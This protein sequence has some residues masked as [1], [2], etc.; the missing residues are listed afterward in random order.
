MS[1]TFKK[2]LLGLVILSFGVKIFAMNTVPVLSL[3][4]KNETKYPLNE[5]QYKKLLAYSALLRDIIGDF[6]DPL[7]QKNM[8]ISLQLAKQELLDIEWLLWQFP[9]NPKSDASKEDYI[10]EITRALNN[11]FGSTNTFPK[12]FFVN[13]LNAG[14]YL[15]LDTKLMGVLIEEFVQKYLAFTKI[16][17]FAQNEDQ[18]LQNILNSLQREIPEQNLLAQIK[19]S[20]K[21]NVPRN[22]VDLITADN[23]DLI[24]DR[25]YIRGIFKK[26]VDQTIA[27]SD[28]S[29][30]PKV[31]MPLK[32]NELKAIIQ[33]WDTFADLEEA[34]QK[35]KK[36]GLPD[37]SV[38]DESNLAQLF[39]QSIQEYGIDL[40]TLLNLSKIS[41][42]N[43]LP[44]QITK[45]IVCAW[46]EKAKK[47]IT[48]GIL[49]RLGGVSSLSWQEI[50]S[51]LGK[52]GIK[53]PNLVKLF[54]ACFHSVGLTQP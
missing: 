30:Y 18:F 47:E 7:K 14:N 21:Q 26:E 46:T 17:Q 49:A 25:K 5:W 43:K 15:Q 44:E 20:F 28:T 22:I 6:G 53:D 37:P 23:K 48:P 50:E 38:K 24:V 36:V 45:T 32:L 52:K 54:N 10:K 19:N 2:K 42:N 3:D 12:D 11:K 31:T 40:A 29:Q 41:F 13:V 33:L 4:L 39:N 51:L 34:S 9:E 8:S 1:F 16:R 35:R 27:Q